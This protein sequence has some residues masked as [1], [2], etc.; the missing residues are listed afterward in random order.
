[1]KI[2]RLHNL[3][4]EA[5]KSKV[6]GLAPVLMRQYGDAVSDAKAD[7]R[8][9]ALLFSFK[10]AGYNLSGTLMATDSSVIVDMA[11]PLTLRPFEGA[12]RARI[13]QALE[14]LFPAG[15]A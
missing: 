10:A 14:E 1:M 8:G 4:Q 5:A 2:I 3:T 13:G 15:P 11:L 9:D 6:Q 7:W 12:I